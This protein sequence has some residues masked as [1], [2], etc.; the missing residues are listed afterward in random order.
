MTTRFRQYWQLLQQSLWFVPGLMVL[1]VGLLAYGLIEFDANT[2]WNGAKR[3]PL[4]FGVGAEGSRGMLTAIAGSMLTVAALT[5]SLTLSA[6]SQVSSQYSPRVLRNFMSDRPNQVVM[7]YFV[8]IFSYCL[9]VLGTIRGSGEE[10]FVP[11]TA[12]LA[13]LVLALG[14][15]AALIFFIHHIA[16]SLQT[17]TI[18]QRI[19]RET[20]AAIDAFFPAGLGAAI[21]GEAEVSVGDE[22]GPLGWQPVKAT[23][24][25][26]L[27]Q[28]G[29]DTLLTWAI[30][31][32]GVVRLEQP[33]GTFIGAGSVLFSVIS[34][35]LPPEEP[36]WAAGLLDCVSIGRHRNVAQDIAFG[37]Q[38]LVDISLKA[39]SP[40]IND[41]TTAIMAI[42]YLSVVI[43]QLASRK[44][45]SRF[46]SDGNQLRVLVYETQFDD[47]VA[48][49]FDFIRINATGNHAV[50]RR[51][52]RAIALVCEQVC[53][54]NRKPVLRKQAHLLVTHA[55]QT[56]STEYEKEQVKNLYDAL[57]PAWS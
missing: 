57:K 35:N 29:T 7:G 28:V 9:I 21:A 26:Y 51:L 48:L 52:L 43:S 8:A 53:D 27:Q 33:I 34:D 36:D 49:A 56:L 17:G 30:K 38:Q 19:A 50:F 3:F 55:N 46:R 22:F 45:P 39:L 31:H 54:Q 47:Y 1:G 4:L 16:E 14:G 37:I 2:S 23:Q 18:V 5:F 11:A 15:V 41:T 44:F 20:S 32:Q 40:G 24:S 13:G 42:D 12:V 10:K 6:I 25:G